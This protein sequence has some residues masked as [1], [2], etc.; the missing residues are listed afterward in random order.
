MRLSWQ[1]PEGFQLAVAVY[2]LVQPATEPK[3]VS[4]EDKNHELLRMENAM[5]DPDTGGQD[6]GTSSMLNSPAPLPGLQALNLGS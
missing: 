5:I 4:V 6:A 2:N 3:S 1:F